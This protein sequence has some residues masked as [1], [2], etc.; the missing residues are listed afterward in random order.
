MLNNDNIKDVLSAVRSD[1]RGC[2]VNDITFCMLC[3]QF[4]DKSVAYNAAYGKEVT[5]EQASKHYA[6]PKMAKLLDAL[7]PFGIG[8]LD[9]DSVTREENKA[10]LLDLLKKV[11][12]PEIVRQMGIKD[13]LNFEKDIR[14][15]L[16]DKFDM[17]ETSKQRRIIVVPQKHDLICPHTHFECTYMPS[18]EACIKYYKIKENAK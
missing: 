15:K 7:K 8:N 12:D 18:R 10:G 14:V 2:S 11:K 16:Q 9:G 17:E 1:W 4:L 5:E 6:S 3:D 13:A